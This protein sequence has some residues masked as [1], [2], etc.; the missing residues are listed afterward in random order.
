MIYPIF[1]S[2]LNPCSVPKPHALI[3]L[4]MVVCSWWLITKG[5]NYTLSKLLVSKHGTEELPVIRFFICRNE[6]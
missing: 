3:N 2:Q 1:D 5:L 6:S 4:K